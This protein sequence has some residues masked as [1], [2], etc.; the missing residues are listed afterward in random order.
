MNT[1]QHCQTPLT[2][3]RA[4]NCSICTEIMSNATRYGVYAFVMS[5]IET[6]K[7]D[8]LTGS[9]LHQVARS[10]AKV[11]GAKQAEWNANYRKEQ[12]ERKAERI[13]REDSKQAF[14]KANGYWPGS[15]SK[16]DAR[17]DIEEMDRFTGGK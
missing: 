17:L 4:K 12:A 16:E 1:C 5:A 9:D 15:D 13:A 7:A 10:A 6:A 8:G 11:G 3:A 2:N 14:Y